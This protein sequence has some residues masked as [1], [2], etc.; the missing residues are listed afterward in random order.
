MF[1]GILLSALAAFINP[2]MLIE[3][4]SIINRPEG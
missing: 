1:S 3:T 4:F 2:E